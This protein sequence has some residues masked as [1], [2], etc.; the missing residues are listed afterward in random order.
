MKKWFKFFSLSYFSHK[1]S[2]EGA[3]RGYANVFLGFILAL[4]FLWVGFV[5]GDMLP[6]GLH[7]NNSP[8]FMATV[9]AVFAN[10]DTNK[11]MDAKIENGVLKV[12]KPGTQYAESL[13][14]NTFERETERQDYSAGGYNVVIDTRPANTLAEV[15]A[16]CLSNDGKNTVISYEEYLTLSDVAKLNFDFK[17]KYTGNALELSDETV[18]GYRAYVA[19]LGDESKEQ[20]EKLEKEL[21]ENRITKEAYIRAVYELYF[22][23]YYPEITAYEGSSKVP[24][25]RNY[26]LHQYINSGIKNYLFVFDDYMTGSFE[27][28]TGIGVPFYGFYSDIENGALV[29]KD[30]TAAQANASADSFIKNAFKGIWFIYAYSY[31]MNVIALV[32]FIVLMLMV[33]ALLAYSVLKLRGVESINSLGAMFKIVGS[34]GWFSGVISA[35][36]SVIIAFFVQ[37][38]LTSALPFVLFFAAL[39]IRAMIFVME[40]SKQ[41]AKQLQQQESSRVSSL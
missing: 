36:L 33:A 21:A 35:V 18:E 29:S 13:L 34:F 22:T 7:Y 37:R 30:A 8:D 40:E 2:K 17:L 5:G 27:T 3:R 4:I 39:V 31:A 20:T 19:A 24:L 12:R 14:I 11:R 32:P 16:Y 1:H 15:E 25:L 26:Y 38:S 9:R 6:F 41:Y 28:S 23:K 10:A